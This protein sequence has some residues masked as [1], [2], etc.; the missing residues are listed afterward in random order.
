MNVW[1][2]AVFSFVIVPV[3]AQAPTAVGLP[4]YD[5]LTNN[6][7]KYIRLTLIATGPN[8]SLALLH[9]RLTDTT[10]RLRAAPGKDAFQ[11]K[12]NVTLT[13]RTAYIGNREVVFQAG[14]S[15][16][17]IQIGQTLAGAI[18]KPLSEE[19]RKE[20]KLPALR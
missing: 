10:T 2:A 3:A 13:G 6:S 19:R 15:Y 5:P 16:Y 20:L 4:G 7:A 11:L 18:R 8:D 14:G 9:D 17:A 1:T 12:G